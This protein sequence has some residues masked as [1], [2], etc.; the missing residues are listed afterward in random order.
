MPTS[1]PP[2]KIH[3]D[4]KMNEKIISDADELREFLNFN[5]PLG[6]NEMPRFGGPAT[7]MRL[8]SQSTARGLDV[9]FVGIPM[10]IGASNRAGN[11]ARSAP[12]PGGE[13]HDQAVRHGQ[14]GRAV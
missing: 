2:E 9:C 14:R 11:A 7:M 1:Y 8:P 3:P 10:D 4:L 5:Q 6:G 12:D 13:L